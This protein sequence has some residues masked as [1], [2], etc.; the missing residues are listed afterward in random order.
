ME[1]TNAMLPCATMSTR[2]LICILNRKLEVL[3]RLKCV[4]NQLFSVIHHSF[5]K[6]YCGMQPGGLP[7]RAWLLELIISCTLSGCV[8][9]FFLRPGVS[10]ALNARLMS[11]TASP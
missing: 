5:A 8:L 4:H 3:Q 11:V 9:N 1:F 10:L 6:G 7:D 2:D